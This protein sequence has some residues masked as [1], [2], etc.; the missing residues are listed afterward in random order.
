MSL[1]QAPDDYVIT[2]DHHEDV[3]ILDSED[4]PTRIDGYQ[5]K[6]KADGYWS[7][8]AITKR[9][10]GSGS[11]PAL[12]PSILGKLYTLKTQFPSET[13]LLQF[14]SNT[15]VRAKLQV[16]GKTQPK[17]HLLF[18]ELHTTVQSEVQESLKGEL[19][20]TAP[21]VLAELLEFR[22]ADV[23]LESH[24]T[25]AKGKLADFLYDMYPE[26]P[27][28]VT[29]IY[30]ALIGEVAFRN[31]NQGPIEKYEDLIRLKSISRRSFN[32]ILQTAGVSPNE[33]KWEAIENRLNSEHAPL[34]LI[35]GLRREW[36]GVELERISA[37]EVI[38]LR[39]WEVIE[40]RCAAHSEITTLVD[41]IDAVYPDVVSAVDRAWPFSEMYIKAAIIMSIY[42]PK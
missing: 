21:P 23:P 40:N 31:N 33:L 4:A 27:F 36:D 14:V 26:R 34:Q 5:I 20:L 16:D 17:D 2:F 24:E 37:A 15:S 42:D 41:A 25:Y 9:Q 39:L 28:R 6:T 7:V 22:T 8:K 10:S 11:P 32:D 1:H 30:R 35:Q 12:L 29:P 3:Q 18:A 13:K 19:K 38:H